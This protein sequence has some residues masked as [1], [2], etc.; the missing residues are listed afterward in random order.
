MAELDTPSTSSL[1][2]ANN[3]SAD[4]YGSR[5]MPRE[6]A[7]RFATFAVVSKSELFSMIDYLV[8]ELP[9]RSLWSAIART[10]RSCNR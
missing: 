2:Q 6:T 5:R 7:D 4:F 10:A 8:S 1:T 9:E 3:P